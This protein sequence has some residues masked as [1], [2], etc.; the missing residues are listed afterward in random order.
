MSVETIGVVLKFNCS[1]PKASFRDILVVAR[2]GGGTLKKTDFIKLKNAVKFFGFL[3]NF[4]V[5]SR[6][7]T[8]A[9]LVGV[10]VVVVVAL[11][12]VVDVELVIVVLSTGHK[13]I[14][15]VVVEAVAVAV[16]AKRDL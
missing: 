7:P 15:V 16:A 4:Y 9:C 11:V 12:R 10:V 6:W 3:F 2:G 1:L 13:H 8:T 5:Y 14:V